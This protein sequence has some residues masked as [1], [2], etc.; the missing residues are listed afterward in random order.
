MTVM[1][2]V[3]KGAGDATRQFGVATANVLIPAGVEPPEGIFAAKT[4]IR[5]ALWPSAACVRQTAEGL[6]CEVHLFGFEGDLYGEE[7]QI[8]LLEQVS[9]L[10]S[11]ENVE[12]MQAKILED[13]ERVKYVLGYH[14]T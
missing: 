12:Q 7:L 11:F 1:G 3:R 6:L 2:I 14:S 10:I 13:L 4:A 8:E 9:P 5:Q